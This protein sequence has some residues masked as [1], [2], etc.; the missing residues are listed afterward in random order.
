MGEAHP[1]RV[2]RGCQEKGREDG[3]KRRRME[4][5][6]KDLPSRGEEGRSTAPPAAKSEDCHHHGNYERTEDEETPV[7]GVRQRAQF[8]ARPRDRVA[9]TPLKGGKDL[10]RTTFHNPASVA[11]TAG[12]LPVGDDPAFFHATCASGMGREPRE[13][14]AEVECERVGVEHALGWISSWLDELPDEL[15][16]ISPKGNI[17]P[18][19]TSL[20]VLSSLFPQHDV[21]RVN[22]LRNLVVSLNSLND[23]GTFYE[24]VPNG[25]QRD[26]VVN[27]M[28]SVDVVFDWNV[29]CD[30]FSWDDFLNVK[31]IDYKGDE[32][33]TARKISWA[34][35]S[36]AL[37]EEV[38]Q[39]DL[40]EVVE[41][42]SF[43]YVTNFEEYL[44][45]E[46]DLTYTR[47]PRVM[48]DD[49]DWEAL[50]SN[51]LERGVFGRVHEED[52]FEVNGKPILNG[53]FGVSKDEF[54]GA[55]TEVMRIIMNLTPINACCRTLDSDI[56]TLPTWSSF[57]PLELL[58]GEDLVVSSEDVRCFFY[59]FRIPPNWFRYMAFNRP[60]PKRLCGDKPGTWYPCS[61]VLPMGFKN[62]V[63]LAQHVHRVL[64]KGALSSL[65]MGGEHE[66]RK[67]KGH[68]SSN[69]LFRIYLDNFDELRK[70]SSAWSHTL[71]GQVSPLVSSLRDEYA[72][73][74]VPRH[75]KK[76]VC[77]SLKAE[78]QGGIVDGRLG[79]I[80]P[81]PEKVLKYAML[82]KMLLQQ[83]TCTQKQMQIVGGGL[84]Y[85]AMFRR[86]M[87]CALN[88]IWQ[89]VTSFEGFPPVIRLEIPLAVKRELVRFL[90]L[91][92][93][94]HI[95]LRAQLSSQVTAS[96]ASSTGGGV[97]VSTGVSPAGTIAA[98][99]DIRGDIVE[100]VDVTQVLT[101]GLFDGVGALRMA[102]DVLGWNVVAHVSVECSKAASRVVES[103]FPNTVFVQDVHDVTPELIKQWSLKFSQVSL[104]MIGAGPPC[105]GVSGLNASKKGAMKDARS[106]LFQVVD[107]IR[108]EFKRHFP[109]AQVRS[110]M[111]SVASMS[112][113]DE[114]H[115]SSHFGGQPVMMN[116]S[117]VSLAH[118]PRL[119][120]VDW[121][122]PPAPDVQQSVLESGR[123]K[124]QL[125]T[126]LEPVD[127]LQPGW[128]RIGLDPLPTFTTSRPSERPPYKPAGIHQCSAEE[129][130]MWERDKFR[131]PPY[132]Y[133]RKNC[134]INK[135]GIVRLPSSEEREVIMG[136][137]KGY[138][139]PCLPKSEQGTTAHEDMRCTLVGNSWNVTTV[140]WLLSRLGV[141]LGLNPLLTAQQIVQR[142]KPGATTDFQTYLLRPSMRIQRTQTG[143]DLS[144]TLVTKL[145]AQVSV[146]GEDLMLQSSHEDHVRYHRLRASIPAKLWKWR[147]VAGWRWKNF[148]EHINVLEM[149]AALTALRWRLIQHRRLN[150]RF[151]HLLDSLV[152]LHAFSRGRSSSRKLKRSLIK[153]NALILAT[154]SQVVWAY[155][156]T[157]QNPA[158]AP[159]R[160][161]RKRKWT[162]A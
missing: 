150:V 18:L 72:S 61:A 43:T 55:G 79:L 44:L 152:C 70:V 110:L 67:D 92:P 68:S 85:L 13:K 144:K 58:D 81:K 73:R 82:T 4:G 62:S 100:P 25:F 90:G 22:G 53:L 89:F 59:I 60:L 111:E 132:Q 1:E 155:V 8:L 104:V 93:L 45:A 99:C 161:P 54:T 131:Y 26:V 12:A 158:D 102:T 76:A 97:T 153:A 145:L 125:T 20:P 122:L 147:T 133:Q 129:L 27:L 95:S 16:K 112:K 49:C 128:T 160:H 14:I 2:Q 41:L 50:C 63:A 124:L 40:C 84:V 108:Q 134:L 7:V 107:P 37:P 127:Y 141:L 46:E 48:V 35:V 69:P 109:W 15:C 162:N 56:A 142:T 139:V 19:P 123:T 42:G 87:L 29:Q 143:K 71:S 32:V 137:P 103:R 148:D 159:S 31:T 117:D 96:D 88:H 52:I 83:R 135:K 106:C 149:R 94:A 77:S 154:H 51:L 11:A 98:Q 80:Y 6:A 118:R 17:F 140:A 78:V 23:E 65:G 130:D 136:M 33:R 5:C 47:P 151:V 138:T 91:V 119:Y 38:G 120:W 34:S 116:S 3:K 57:A 74:G 146:K 115:M 21:C 126:E 157:K 101:V 121:E 66:M 28:Q 86:P 10:L 36:P 24:G 64:T 75:P 30:S 114:D 105:Q 156:H 39:V 9:A 113:E